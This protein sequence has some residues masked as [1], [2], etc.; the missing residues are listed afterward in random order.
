MTTD[1]PG[2]RGRRHHPRYPGF[3]LHPAKGV[4]EIG[5]D[6]HHSEFFLA[7]PELFG[8]DLEAAFADGWVSIRRWTGSQ[9]VWAIRCERFQSVAEALSRWAGVCLGRFPDEAETP[10]RIFTNEDETPVPR[11]LAE[12]ASEDDQG[13][14]GCQRPP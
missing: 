11:T 2:A 10:L 9:E 6:A 1:K 4:Y 12:L 3:W 8:T 13:R 5:P 7:H 14:G